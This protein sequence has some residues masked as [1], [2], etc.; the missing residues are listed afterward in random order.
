MSGT[1]ELANG[2]RRRLQGKGKRNYKNEAKHAEKEECGGG[3]GEEETT[4]ANNR[5]CMRQRDEREKLQ[6]GN[7]AEAE[8]AAEVVA[9]WRQRLQAPYSLLYLPLSLAAN[10]PSPSLTLHSSLFLF[11]VNNYVKAHKND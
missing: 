1:L 9:K 5:K 7:D 3:E 4:Q 10:T 8:D 11:N 6:S 2:R